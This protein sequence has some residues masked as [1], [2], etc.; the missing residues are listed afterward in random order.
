[1]VMEPITVDKAKTIAGKKGLKPGRVKGTNGIQFTKG[2]NSRLEVID[3]AEFENRDRLLGLLDLVLPFSESLA[4]DMVAR[5]PE[6][7][8]AALKRPDET[9]AT[10]LIRRFDTLEASPSVRERL[11]DQLDVPLR[12]APGP[13]TPCRTR[14]KH[15]VPRP[16]TQR[17]PLDIR[18]PKGDQVGHRGAL[19][20]LLQP[21]TEIIDVLDQDSAGGLGEVEERL[22]PRGTGRLL[23]KIGSQAVRVDRLNA[24]VGTA[25][26]FHHLLQIVLYP[27]AAEA[28]VAV[29]H[30]QLA[31]RRLEHPQGLILVLRIRT[32]T[33]KK[34]AVEALGTNRPGH[35]VTEYAQ[36]IRLRYV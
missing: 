12:L 18:R 13:E 30:P 14:A 17:R 20:H 8:L 26:G 16:V 34:P 21:L 33:E 9:D 2:G 36:S 35:F 24:A 27:G 5:T 22:L 31:A 11:Y 7:W 3:W 1:M 6:E 23:D 32:A 25:K 19:D 28:L 15:P 10:F 4:L 29:H